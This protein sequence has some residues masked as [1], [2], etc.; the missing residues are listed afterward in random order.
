MFTEQEDDLARGAS[1]L[2]LF[3]LPIRFAYNTISFLQVIRWPN[4]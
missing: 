2:S 4:S 3:T 1:G